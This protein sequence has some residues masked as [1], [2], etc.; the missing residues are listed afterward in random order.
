MVSS[1]AGV[2]ILPNAAEHDLCPLQRSK[3]WQH[4]NSSIFDLGL[5]Y[6]LMPVIEQINNPTSN[7]VMAFGISYKTSSYSTVAKKKSLHLHL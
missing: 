1:G 4:F 3:E 6:M 2:T 5:S 7:R